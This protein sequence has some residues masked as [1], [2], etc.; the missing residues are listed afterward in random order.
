MSFTEDDSDNEP[1]RR[2]DLAE[3]SPAPDSPQQ[4]SVEDEP[5]LLTRTDPSQPQQQGEPPHE[6]LRLLDE[7]DE[8]DPSPRSQEAAAAP[9]RRRGFLK[10]L[11]ATLAVLAI[12]VAIALIVAAVWLRHSMRAA[13]PQID[14]T[15]H[16]A[17][18]TAP[19]TI[20]RDAQGVP[21]ISA[22]NLDDL[23]FAQGFVTAQDRLW[24]M[25]ILRRHAAG[26]LAEIL[27]PRLVDHD[28]RQRYLQLRAAADRA[29]QNLPPDQLHQFQAYA[30]GVNAFID[31]HR[32]LLPVEF[33]LLHYTPRAWTPRDSLLVSLV[34][35]QDLSTSFPEKLNRESLSRHLPPALLSDVYPTGS[36]RDRPPTEPPPDLTA[37]RA[38]EQIP[39]DNTQSK[40]E[41]PAPAS[42]HDLLAVSA[43]LSLPHCEDCRAGSNNWAVAASRSASGAPLVSNDMHLSLSIPDIWYEAV[44]HAPGTSGNFSIDVEGFTLPGIPWVL[45]GRNA[46]VAWGFTN[47]GADIQDIRIEHLR[48][49]GSDTEYQR[50]D[51]AW[52]PV[53]HHA[54]QIAVRGGRNL[55]LDVET[56]PHTVGAAAAGTTT[57]ETPIISPL[58]PSEHR[59]L[60]L[61]WT[62]YDPS[63]LNASFLPI[64]TA[65]DGASLV[66]AFATFGGPSLNLIYA[67]D[68]G[69]IGYHALGRIPI[70]GPAV[71]HPRAAPQFVIPEPEPES[72]ED[73]EDTQAQLLPPEST[74]APHW[75]LTAYE[76]ARRRTGRRSLSASQAAPQ[77]TQP[78]AQD[79]TLPTPPLEQNYSIGSPISPIPVDALNADQAWSSY[80][81]YEA[82][83]SIQD[84]ASGVLAT[85]NA[86]I[87][88]DNYPYALTLDWVD[89]YR[90]ERIDHLLE[91]RTG[92]TPQS[93]LAI[94][95]DQHSEFDLLLA[96]RIAYAIDHASTAARARDASRLHQAANLLRSW[97][98]NMSAN[99]PAAAIVAATHAE[100]WPLLL[101]PQIV[102]H[103]HCSRSRAQ[104]LAHLYLWNEQTT[105]LEDLLAHN[106]A[107]WL[108]FGI[109]SWD[110]LL[111]D[112]TERGLRNAHAPADL[113]H[114]QYGATHQI[115]IEHPLFIDRPL[116]RWMLG[117]SPG[118]GVHAAGGDTT[119]IDAFGRSF[120]SSERFTAD[121]ANPDAALAN[122]TTGESGNPDSP[123]YL[124]QFLPW[125]RGT[126]FNLPLN[127]P[128]TKHT[129]TLLP[130]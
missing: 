55:T 92:L 108:P 23:L 97:Q 120:G 59:A 75:Q 27:G 36:W 31:T 94:Q 10:K 62:L 52:L 8:I 13:M 118:S 115:A 5:R 38:I 40:V 45:A 57:M 64:D 51:G 76:P 124:D 127:N 74:I 79:Q 103:D 1:P 41:S 117:T 20:S 15:L 4:S 98:G 6:R 77:S 39:L 47:L 99:S 9:R 28:K 14:G 72:D 96:Q 67:D 18:L 26:E 61:A 24:Q 2:R 87:T 129:L 83:P 30:R 78:A 84:P 58:F 101:V 130:D 50:P 17:G 71:Q 89:P 32:D 105:A 43:A 122:L 22:A 70:R 68:Q 34:M 12:L 49:S 116:V 93:M 60:S 33:H 29:A 37:P 65:T 53:E 35:W 107:R 44:L 88:P 54:E 86:R 104:T 16:I 95:N 126:T 48:G 85:A 125:L 11:L 91:N 110:D 102:A 25:D 109:A 119:T 73:D 21:S 112:A 81:P 56:I 19:V 42:P 111:T 121:L 128:G 80:I 66:A 3:E 106:P 123:W 46:H 69:H 63:T 82:L 114:W 100:L 113:S 7:I 90:V